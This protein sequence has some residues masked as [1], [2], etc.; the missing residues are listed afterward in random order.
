MLVLLAC[1]AQGAHAQ[2]SAE[3]AVAEAEDAFGMTVGR[4]AIGLYSAM[5]ARGFSPVQAGNIRIDGLYF[6]QV[7]PMANLPTRLVRSATVHVGIAAQG[8]LFPAPTGVVDYLLR[9]PGNATVVSILVGDASYGQTYAETDAQVAIIPDVLS[10][11][12]GIGYT[13][14]ADYLYS[15]RSYESSVGWLARWQ[16][17]TAL[18]VTPFWGMINHREFGER[19]GVLIDDSGYPRFRADRLPAPPWARWGFLWQT[20]GLTSRYAFGGGWQLSAGLF[21]SLSYSPGNDVPLLLD[22]NGSNQG[23]YEFEKAPPNSDGSTSGE[24]RLSKRLDTGAIHHA[25]YAR[26]TG[27]DSS[28]ES[29]GAQTG[30]LGPA[31]TTYLPPLPRPELALGANTIVR[32]R[33]LTPGLSYAASWLGLAQLTLG[34]QRVY[35][36][37]TI[38]APNTPRESDQSTPWLY[39]AAA[40]GSLTHRLLFYTS[41]TRGFEEIGIAPANASNRF[42]P[43]PAQ[44]DRQVDAGLRYQLLPKLQ[45]VTGVFEI[46]K[47]YANLDPQNVF[48]LVGNTR[49]RGVEFS[50]TGDITSRLNIVSGVVL[51]RPTVNYQSGVYPGP[52]NVIAIGPIPGYMSTY[53]QYHPA[54]IP[55]LI[56]GATL[57]NTSSRYAVY[58][59]INLPAVTTFGIDVRYHTQLW[60]RDATFWLESYNL[61]SVYSLTPSATG[62]VTALD[63]RRFELSLVIDF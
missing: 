53:I 46:D 22:T 61:S 29:G 25:I 43:V 47:P 16:P 23:I 14:N 17:N 20:F 19:P 32:A 36:H 39:N 27:R 42:E 59:N 18:I 13:R 9:V 5:S 58:P 56:L 45:L 38:L 8:Y 63:A 7:T 31:T 49:N 11:G 37:R 41:Y 28:I 57:Q 33:Q 50:L 62:Q 55:G 34:V 52:A 2:R 6:D 54:A 21:R 3:D 30:P 12:G 1:A 24:V 40:A 35:Y 44:L 15:P 48:R 10:M 60:G 4:E 51:I 26:I